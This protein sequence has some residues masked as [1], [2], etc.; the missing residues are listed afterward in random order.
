[1][2]ARSAL[3]LDDEIVH[4]IF[5]F[6]PNSGT[7]RCMILV[8]KAFHKVY[9]ANLKATYNIVGP[10]LPQ[11]LRVL[12]YPYETPD[13]VAR[14]EEDPDTLAADCPEDH[15]ASVITPIEL[16]YL[17]E[18]SEVIV[19]LEDI[20]SVTQKDRSSATSV[21]TAV[22]SLRF[23]RAAYRIMFYCNLFPSTSGRL[24]GDELNVNEITHIQIQRT[25]ML[26]SYPTDELLQLYAVL[27]FFQRI[28]EQVFDNP[29]DMDVLLTLGPRGAKRAWEKRS[30]GA[31]LRK[32]FK[33]DFDDDK[34]CLCH[35]YF[36][37][38]LENI[39]TER[40][41]DPPSDEEP[42]T[43]FILDSIIG[44]DDTCSQCAAPGGLALLTQANWSRTQLLPVQLLKS[45]L[46]QNATLWTPL[47]QAVSAHMADKLANGE[48][49]PSY[50]A[51]GPWIKSVFG[52]PKTSEWDGWT[53]DKSYCLPCLTKFLEEHVWR[54]LL[55]ER[56]KAGW[57]P[58]EDCRYGY[59]CRSM[60]HKP[61][62]AAGKNHLCVPKEDN[63]FKAHVLSKDQ[64]HTTS[65][66]Q[67]DFA[68]AVLLPLQRQSAAA[69]YGSRV[70]RTS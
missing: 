55:Q 33:L 36:S 23:R 20:Y 9:Q 42:A 26:A 32:E 68:A 28:F 45:R 31:L 27:R 12:R 56:I 63:D 49:L 59:D 13:G 66:G 17:E 69:I 29:S 30:Y 8:S 53:E 15:A 43:R 48:D 39:W 67:R 5:T 70:C 3:S 58:P 41:V 1:M 21:L 62:H 18:N 51:D 34:D 35:R 57:S 4:R 60:V 65:L 11:A 47:H 19:A 14:M 38:P 22:E 6:C 16:Q 2:R 54:W 25:A 7:L 44:A 64:E 40:A 46:K 50:A 52:V 37:L 61:S 24:Y 10:A